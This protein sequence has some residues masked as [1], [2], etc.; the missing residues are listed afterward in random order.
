MRV[1]MIANYLIV[2][3]YMALLSIS[4]L[5]IFMSKMDS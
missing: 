5:M 1:T 2:N 3:Y 4:I